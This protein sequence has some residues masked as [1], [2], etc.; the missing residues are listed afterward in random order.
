MIF[1]EWRTIFVGLPVV[2]GV[3]LAVNKLDLRQD[4]RFATF[5]GAVAVVNCEQNEAQPHSPQHEHLDDFS[6]N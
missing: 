4:R 1:E 2:T 5:T 3:F 6:V